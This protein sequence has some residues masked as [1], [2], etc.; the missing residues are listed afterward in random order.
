MKLI[1]ISKGDEKLYFSTKKNASKYLNLVYQNFNYYMDNNKEYKG[2]TF[3]ECYD[4]VMTK[5]VDIN[6]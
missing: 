6:I 1:K 2:W 3:E 4:N 5:D